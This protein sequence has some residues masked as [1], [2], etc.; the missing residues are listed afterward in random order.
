MNISKKLTMVVLMGSGS[1][2]VVQAVAE[3]AAQEVSNRGWYVGGEFGS[4]QG[5]ADI[6]NLYSLDEE[7]A[8]LGVYGGYNFTNWFGLEGAVFRSSNLADERPE[9]LRAE[10]ATVSFMPKFTATLGKKVGLFAK[11]GLTYVSYSEEYDDYDD[12]D[13]DDRWL[14]D[15][16]WGEILVGGAIGTLIDIRDGVQLRVSYDHVSGTLDDTWFSWDSPA[17]HVDATLSRVLVGVHYQF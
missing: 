15:A 8:G 7:G 10:F 1:L 4:V 9:L 2:S 14:D 16:E 3:T 11:A 5:E 6:G 13:D 12:D 17:E